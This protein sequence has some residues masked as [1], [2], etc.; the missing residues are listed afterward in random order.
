MIH[1]LTQIFSGPFI[2]VVVLIP[3][4][5]FVYLI[6]SMTKKTT[7]KNLLVIRIIL[8][9]LSFPLL[10]CLYYLFWNETVSILVSLWWLY[11]ILPVT[12]LVSIYLIFVK[13]DKG[14]VLLVTCL[15]LFCFNFIFV[16]IEEVYS[17]KK[18]QKTE[19]KKIEE[20]S[21]I[22]T[23]IEN[24][25]NKKGTYPDDLEEIN[26][27]DNKNIVHYEPSENGKNISFHFR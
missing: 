23:K 16:K 15:L 6:E 26:T 14:K 12:F 2:S 20:F 10:N 24:H 7:I 13:K 8:I 4:F 27:P 9:S 21:Y 22:I 17:Y 11:L 25:K 1:L 3:A 19:K 5:A 18:I